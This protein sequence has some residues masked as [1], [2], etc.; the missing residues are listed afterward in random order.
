MELGDLLIFKTVADEGGIINAA[1]KLHRVQSSVSTRIRQLESSI[2]AQ[3]FHRDK[4]RLTLSPAGEL[5]LGYAER[6]LRLSEE[7]RSALSGSAPRG[8]LKLGSLE[9]TAASRLPEILADYHRA[10]PDVLIELT[11]GT[12]DALTA[13]VAE[14][15]LD[16]A[17]VAERPSGRRLS[18]MELF[19]E[20]LV[21]IS[22]VQHRVIRGPQDIEG[23]SVIAFPVGCAYRRVLHRWLGAKR[24]SK[25]PVLEL[26]SYHAIVACVASG[27]G[28]ALVPESVL[29][30][31]QHRHISKHR[32]PRVYAE[33]ITPLVWRTAEP[34]VALIAFQAA[35][36]RRAG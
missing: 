35:L 34:S 28:I 10:H 5:L 29:A 26:S 15:S 31:I 24:A 25:A 18:S 3:L 7:A 23:D 22:S 11:T 2:G 30:T 21:I 12:N 13:A 6:L 17:F 4:Q 32:L 19:A 36:R 14:G 9:S 33:V 8:V 16:A 1:R 20:R 27:T